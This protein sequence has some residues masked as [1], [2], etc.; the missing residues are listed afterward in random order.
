VTANPPSRTLFGGNP[1][2]STFLLRDHMMSFA[3]TGDRPFQSFGPTLGLFLA[4]T[5]LCLI[6]CGKPLEVSQQA[7]S[8]PLLERDPAED[9]LDLGRWPGWRG[10]ASQGIARGGSPPIELSPSDGYRW[11]ATVPGKGLSSPVVWDN[12]I[13]LT[14]A[15]NKTDPATLAVLCFDRTDGTL[16]WQTEAGKA[17]GRTHAKNGYASAS[18]ATDGR[19][20]VAFFGSTG[21][22]CYD[23]SGEQL[24]HADLGD[25]DHIW[26]T[27]ASPVLYGKTVIQMCDSAENSYI[28]AFDIDSGSEV[29]HTD[30]PSDGSWS[31]P[32]FIEVAGDA[33]DGSDDHTEMIVNGTSGKATGRLVI[34]YDPADGSELWRVEGTTDLVTPT[35]LIGD[36]LVYSLSGR[37]G[38]IMA[39]QPGGSGDVTETHV[40]W[41]R[42][43][44]GP[45]IP[46]GVA[47]RNRIFV[48]GDSGRLTCYNGGDGEKVWDTKLRGPFTS[49]LIAADGQI[50]AINERGTVSVFAAADEFELLA[51][52]DLD[53][54]CLT[55]PAVVD[56][57]LLIRTEG[58][59]FCFA[60]EV[61]A[62]TETKAEEP[63]PAT[64][65]TAPE[66]DEPAKPR[67]KS[68]QTIEQSA[69]ELTDSWPVFRG[70]GQATGVAVG[71]LPETLELLWTFSTDDG[72]FESTAAIVDGSV[73]VGCLD[74]N[75]YAIDLTTGKKR[76]GFPTDLGFTAS[77]A[78]R[79]GRVYIGDYDGKLYCLDAESGDLLWEFQT[80]AEINSSANFY[81]DTVLFGSQDGILYCL[82]AE[83]GEVAFQYESQ[84]MIQ[85]SPAVVDD[86]AFVAGCDGRLHVVDLTKGERIGDVDLSAPT[87]CTP[88]IRR[89][90][91]FVGTTGST[92]F[93]VDWQKGEVVW[94]YENPERAAEIRSSAAVTAKA[95]IVGSQDKL[96]HAVDIESG[97]GLWTFTTKARVD[98]SPVVVGRRVF[99]G[100]A[101]GRI[102]ALD[103]ESGEELWQFEAGGS[104]LASPAVAAGRLVI[105]TDEGDLYCFGA[106]EQVA[107]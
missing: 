62:E 34:A 16:L 42:T 105:G 48:V 59:L 67:P 28:A 10:W 47:Y 38:P 44:G 66:V 5:L 50:Y 97:E 103:L 27:A 91:A 54:G 73:Y 19:R 95:V 100:S 31:T 12:F 85:C 46:S 80:D 13:L 52:N 83:S 1:L 92:L 4:L 86:R 55:T 72:G 15:L 20:I 57:D 32:V 104:I 3:R 65:D 89:N 102:Y 84:D 30:R 106:K 14:T 29:W 53:A 81:K 98:S 45:Y 78:V 24:W 49:S 58:E 71:T 51:T 68:D 74:G 60:G 99:V 87:L 88:A 21:L 26:G 25:L 77:P 37:N 7:A 33:K 17:I 9:G 18:V 22:F 76:W 94:T 90:M 23:F 69:E 107:E 43:R 79:D 61:Q 35:M 8:L 93:G 2:A 63:A 41:K 101:D 96:V 11:K 6:G 56:G 39:I 75:L 36:G 82:D 70:D 64:V 40:Q